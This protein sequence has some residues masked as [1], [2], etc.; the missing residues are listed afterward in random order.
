MAGSKGRGEVAPQSRRASSDA[1][2]LGWAG[3][4]LSVI[5]VNLRQKASEPYL[6][7][8]IEMMI[9]GVGAGRLGHGGLRVGREGGFSRPGN[10]G[11]E[12]ASARSGSLPVE[13]TAHAE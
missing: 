6:S 11:S 7:R 10:E 12:L 2:D 1:H 4:N 3:S 13:R 8:S 9:R 5:G